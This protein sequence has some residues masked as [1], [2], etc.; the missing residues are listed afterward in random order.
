MPDKL[1]RVLTA[2]P[3]WVWMI[4]FTIIP[5]LLVVYYAFLGEDGG[6]TAQNIVDAATNANY[7]KSILISFRHALLST[8]V[9]L[10]LGYPAAYFLSKMKKG[11]GFILAPT[12]AIPQDVPGENVMAMLKC[13]QK[14]C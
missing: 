7:L 3:L 10:L 11:G 6:F 12:H 13:F 4:C 1:K 14:Y 9:C 5:M 2:T 8:A